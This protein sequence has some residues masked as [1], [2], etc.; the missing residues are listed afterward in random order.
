MTTNTLTLTPLQKRVLVEAKP[1]KEAIKVAFASIPPK[2]TH[3]ILEYFLLKADGEKLQVA[4]YDLSMGTIAE[5]PLIGA[6]DCA[7]RSAGGDRSVSME[8]A[9]AVPAKH[10]KKWLHKHKSSKKFSFSYV[11][12]DVGEETAK[13]SDTGTNALTVPTMPAGEFPEFPQSLEMIGTFIVTP[14]AIAP[15]IP[16]V[17]TDVTKQSINFINFRA[18]KGVL[19][20]TATDGHKASQLDLGEVDRDFEVNIPPRAFQGLPQNSE[21]SVAFVKGIDNCSDHVILKV[22]DCIRISRIGENSFP[23]FG[24]SQ[25]SFQVEVDKKWLANQL[26]IALA[27]CDRKYRVVRLVVSNNKFEIIGEWEDTGAMHASTDVTSN[28][29]FDACFSIDSLIDIIKPM[30]KVFFSASKF[31]SSPAYGIS[32][33][34]VKTILMPVQMKPGTRPERM[35]LKDSQTATE[36]PIE[37]QSMSNFNFANQI[38]I[39]LDSQIRD[40]S[41]RISEAELL[42]AQLR[43]TQKSLETEKQGVLTLAQAG[44]SALQQAANFLGLAT[45][46]GRVDMVDAFWEGIENLRRN[47]PAIAPTIEPQPTPDNDGSGE[48]VE[49]EAVV[50]FST[51]STEDD[52]PVDDATESLREDLAEDGV[53]AEIAEKVSVHVVSGDAPEP[54]I[55][56][57]C[58]VVEVDNPSTSPEIHYEIDYSAFSWIQLRKLARDN[59]IN[60]SGMTGGRDRQK[61]EQLLRDAKVVPVVV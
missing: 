17:S 52:W 3:R 12:I 9:I 42:L 43:E 7:E 38:V 25:D 24:I 14:K 8:W 20:A 57:E 13:F 48:V 27:F 31:C 46:S 58:E 51:D 11:Q 19:T 47:T 18:Q 6:S 49:V 28:Y 32:D 15:L 61:L 59:G 56:E 10:L 36:Q 4:A 22:D 54:A 55:A 33:G 34:D 37:E 5:M 1:F 30:Q 45:S 21:V 40:V 44:E 50:D 26:A 53:P 41:D 16:C 35:T 23:K 39:G 29:E 60:V 2:P